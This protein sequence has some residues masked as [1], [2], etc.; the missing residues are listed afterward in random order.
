MPPMGSNGIEREHAGVPNV[1]PIGR[2]RKLFCFF[3]DTVA[4]VVPGGFAR[5][6]RQER[7]QDQR[8]PHNRIAIRCS[9]LFL[10]SLS[11]PVQETR[12]TR[13]R[14]SENLQHAVR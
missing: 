4:C 1:Q 5:R 8:R 6:K 2:R 10:P 14:P 12:G 13:R 3:L 7:A 9:H 11:R